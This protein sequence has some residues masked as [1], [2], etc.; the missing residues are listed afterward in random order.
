MKKSFWHVEKICFFSRLSSAKFHT[1]LNNFYYWCVAGRK[2]YY[3]TEC[4]QN[5]EKKKTAR[6]GRAWHIEYKT[7]SVCC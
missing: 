4:I 6:Q 2:I 1:K 3:D 5:I 7:S